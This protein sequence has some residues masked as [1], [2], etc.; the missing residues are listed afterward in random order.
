MRFLILG[1][2]GYSARYPENTLLA[3]REAVKA[4]ADGVELDV[5]LT[6]DG[7]VV[8]IHDPTLDRTSNVRGRVRDKTLKEVKEASL[9]MGQKVPTLREVLEEVEGLINVE[10]K[11]VEAALP[12]LQVVREEGALDRVLFSSFHPEA[13]L[14]IWN[15]CRRVR[16]GL[17]V[18][19]DLKPLS[20]FNGELFSVHVPVELAL[21]GVPLNFKEKVVLWTEKDQLLQKWAPRLVPAIP[22]YMVITD[23]VERMLR[24]RQ[25]TVGL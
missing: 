15:S 17:L 8:V 23:D 9:G 7:E 12:S 10:V 19:G 5:R 11:E 6:R 18:E 14:R 16:M 22:A 24:L 21:T 20:L 13:L 25:G 3:F 4:G 1:H 2:R